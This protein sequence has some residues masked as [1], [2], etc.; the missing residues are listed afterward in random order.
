MLIGVDVNEKDILPQDIQVDGFDNI[1]EVLTTSPA[2][3]DQY[4][5]AARHMAKAGVGNM[6]PP[7]SSHVYP[8]RMATRTLR[9]PSLQD[10]VAR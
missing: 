10:C 7:I 9:C 2:F 1:A 3:L 4:I 6:A 8:D 5:T